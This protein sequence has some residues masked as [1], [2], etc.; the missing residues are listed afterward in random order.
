MV[1]TL[2]KNYCIVSRTTAKKVILW[3]LHVFSDRSVG[4]EFM[5]LK[6]T[7]RYDFAFSIPQHHYL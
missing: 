5:M 2:H 1:Y 3:L 6:I 4:G 7:V